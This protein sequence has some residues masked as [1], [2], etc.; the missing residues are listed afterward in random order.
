[1]TKNQVKQS[2]N[3]SLNENTGDSFTIKIKLC[4]EK[5]G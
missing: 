2:E 1:M 5:Y 4:K 3:E